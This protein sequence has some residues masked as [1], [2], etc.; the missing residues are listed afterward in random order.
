MTFAMVL[1]VCAHQSTN[2]PL[3][4]SIGLAIGSLPLFL[5]QSGQSAYDNIADIGAR[6]QHAAQANR[7]SG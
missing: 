4:L 2:R 1:A 7:G 3:P 5:I 6:C